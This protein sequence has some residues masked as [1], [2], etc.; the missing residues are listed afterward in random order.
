MVNFTD[1][2]A[3]K[4]LQDLAAIR[5]KLTEYQYRT[6]ATLDNIINDIYVQLT[7]K[8]DEKDVCSII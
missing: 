4:Y 8:E 7:S 2:Q 1:K 6:I 3:I 5:S